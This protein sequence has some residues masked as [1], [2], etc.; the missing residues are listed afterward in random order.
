M[1]FQ[2]AHR[3]K[4]QYKKLPTQFQ[5]QF[6]HRLKLFVDDPTSPQLRVHPLS[7]KYRGY[8]SL[9]INGDLR[10]LYLKEGEEI[11]IFALIGTQSQLYG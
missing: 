7:G 11:I 10:A 2:Y 8:W 5:K 9:N 1:I 6:D 3:F 4:K